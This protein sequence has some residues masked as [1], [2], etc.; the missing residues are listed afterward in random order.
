M[1]SRD[2]RT[3]SAKLT[4]V[5]KSRYIENPLYKIV[6]TNN[7]TTY[8]YTKADI[9]PSRHTEMKYT[10]KAQV[11][12]D[13]NDATIH[14]IDLEGFKGVLS[15]GATTADGDEYDATAPLWVVGQQRDSHQ[16]AAICSLELVGVPDLMAR[17]HANA[18]YSQESDDSNTIKDLMDGVAGGTLAPFDHCAAV[19]ITYD[20]GYDG[21]NDLINNLVPADYFSVNLGD[22]RL[23]TLIGLIGWTDNV[24]RFETDG[25][26]H[27]LKPVTTGT[28]YDYDYRLGAAYHNFLS[29]RFRRRVVFPNKII[30]ANHPNQGEYTG[31]ATSSTSYGLIPR[32][33]TFYYRATSDAQ[34]TNIAEALILKAEMDAEQGSARLHYMNFGAEVHDYVNIVDS[35]TSDNRAGNMSWLTRNFGGGKLAMDFGFGKPSMIPLNDLSPLGGDGGGGGTAGNINALYDYIEQIVELLNGMMTVDQFNQWYSDF[36]SDAWFRKLTVVE[37]LLIPTWT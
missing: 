26:I 36:I 16:N 7:G 8:T 32:E 29:K 12:L 25:E 11:F 30:V 31:N 6:L 27:I 10:H 3:L 20:S 28:S 18:T 21:G 22:T 5:Q 2:M 4:A 9:L 13:D 14:G 15:Y 17:D 34:C 33:R 23:Q 24:M 1:D 19:T 35:R 37:Q